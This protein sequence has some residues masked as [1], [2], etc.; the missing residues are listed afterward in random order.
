MEHKCKAIGLDKNEWVY[1]YVAFDSKKEN[2]VIIQ[3]QGINEQQHTGV[4]PETVCQFTGHKDK[5]GKDVYVGDVFKDVLNSKI[6]GLVKFGEYTNCFD[7]EEIK[8]GGHVGFYV[9]FEVPHMRKDLKYWCN[10]SESI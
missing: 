7:K 3:K 8:H 6:S 2:A 9:D 10:H 1:G 4:D 5:Q